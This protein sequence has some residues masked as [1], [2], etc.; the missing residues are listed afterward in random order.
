MSEYS[1]EVFTEFAHS[2][3][4][5]N[6]NLPEDV[7]RIEY[8]LHY[9]R[10]LYKV[11]IPQTLMS[12]YKEVDVNIQKFPF[13]DDVIQITRLSFCDY[14]EKLFTHPKWHNLLFPSVY[15]IDVS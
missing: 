12:N 14:K 1:I 4:K 15:K 3:T 5:K 10:E 13:P 2:Y 11:N 7:Y 6:V 8:A 9:A